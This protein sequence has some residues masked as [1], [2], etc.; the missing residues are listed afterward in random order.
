MM[1]SSGLSTHVQRLV[2]WLLTQHGFQ[3]VLHLLMMIRI[4][5]VILIM[6]LNRIMMMKNHL[7]TILMVDSVPITHWRRLVLSHVRLRYIEPGVIIRMRL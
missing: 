7:T 4:M 5:L 6:I 2:F 3:V 1:N